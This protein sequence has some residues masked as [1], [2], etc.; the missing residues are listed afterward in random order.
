MKWIY[1]TKQAIQSTYSERPSGSQKL[2]PPEGRKTKSGLVFPW[3][4]QYNKYEI[5]AMAG[6]SMKVFWGQKLVRANHHERSVP[7]EQDHIENRRHELQ[8]V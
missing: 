2:S 1:L 4:T 5:G 6:C 8:H 7:Y 3:P